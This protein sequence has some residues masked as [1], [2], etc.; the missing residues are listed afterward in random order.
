M[1]FATVLEPDVM[2][3]N[4]TT[5]WNDMHLLA[6]L[7]FTKPVSIF[8]RRSN[9]SDLICCQLRRS[10]AASRADPQ[11]RDTSACQPGAGR[12]SSLVSLGRF[13]SMINDFIGFPE[14]FSYVARQQS[15]FLLSYDFRRCCC[16]SMWVSHFVMRV[17]SA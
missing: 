10:C 2:S 17:P 3:N 5:T 11:N 15:R 13:Q 8:S 14:R 16:L 4:M 9:E 12:L 6:G 1:A 7:M